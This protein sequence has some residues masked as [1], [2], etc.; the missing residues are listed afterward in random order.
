MDENEKEK[1]KRKKSKLPSTSKGIKEHSGM[2]VRAGS[3]L[4]GPRLNPFSIRRDYQSHREQKNVPRQER[5]HWNGRVVVWTEPQKPRQERFVKYEVNTEKLLRDLEKGNEKILD[6]MAEQIEKNIEKSQATDK[7]EIK[8]TE[9]ENETE[10][11]LN[12]TSEKVINDEESKAAVPSEPNEAS[13]TGPQELLEKA[14]E[15]VIPTLDATEADESD[16]EQL[17]KE[18]KEGEAVTNAE[19]DTVE[20]VKESDSNDIAEKQEIE[21]EES[22][23]SSEDKAETNTNDIANEA[24][25][26]EEQPEATSI[27]NE[28]EALQDIESE[29]D[30]SKD[31]MADD[32]ELILL[33]P[34]FWEEVEET[35]EEPEQVEPIEEESIADEGEPAF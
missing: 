4:Y 17:L 12:V 7:K 13:E 27:E 29:S 10:P 5:T 32:P 19:A 30:S 24:N 31:G 34:S 9:E 14:G 26:Q 11:I 16:Y 23:E 2:I 1:K 15:E 6:K 33:S 35:L 28:A 22:L 21:H 8:D 18:L 3:G 20:A 25:F